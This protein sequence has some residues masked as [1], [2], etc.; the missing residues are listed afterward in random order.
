MGRIA[1]G[2]FNRDSYFLLNLQSKGSDKAG[3]ASLQS[4]SFLHVVAWIAR[5]PSRPSEKS[6]PGKELFLFLTR[7]DK[8]RRLGW[9]IRTDNDVAM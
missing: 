9:L 6:D 1:I 5:G 4:V 8:R 3:N 2:L 7:K